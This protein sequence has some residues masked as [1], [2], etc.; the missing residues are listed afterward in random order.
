MARPSLGRTA[1]VQF[2]TTPKIRNR[3]RHLARLYAGGNVTAWLEHA[4]VNAPRKILK[5]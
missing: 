5:K 2:R 4:G 3:I 1:V